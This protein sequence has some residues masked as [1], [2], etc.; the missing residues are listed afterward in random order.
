MYTNWKTNRNRKA[1]LRKLQIR[2]KRFFRVLVF[3]SGCKIGIVTGT[4]YAFAR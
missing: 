2:A 1:R 4:G 3:Y